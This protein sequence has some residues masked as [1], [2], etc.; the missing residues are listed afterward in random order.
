MIKVRREILVLCF[1]CFISNYS[2][3]H[4]QSKI[5]QDLA[6]PIKSLEALTHLLIKKDSI[7]LKR[8]VTEEGYADIKSQNLYR[9]G[10]KWMAFLRKKKVTTFHDSE[11]LRILKVDDEEYVL[12]FILDKNTKEWKFTAF[13][14]AP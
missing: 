12:S 6:T 4:S 3:L 5:K 14:T 8:I 9:F 7:A 11:G 10:E 13:I 1:V 2:V